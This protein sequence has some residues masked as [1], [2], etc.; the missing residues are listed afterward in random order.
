MQQ[1]KTDELDLLTVYKSFKKGLFNVLITIFNIFEFLKRNWLILTILLLIGLGLGFYKDTKDPQLKS[2][3]VLLKVNFKTVNYIYT[4][5]ETLN[6]KI[7]DNDTLF[8]KNVGFS[9]EPKIIQSIEITPLL[10]FND[11]VST[12]GSSNR[13][14]EALVKNLDINRDNINELFI[15]NL[16]EHMLK[17]DLIGDNELCEEEVYKIINYI[18]QNPLLNNLKNKNNE[19]LK[20]QISTYQEALLKTRKILDNYSK[21]TATVST[22][23]NMIVVDKNFSIDLILEKLKYIENELEKSENK[24]VYASQIAMPLNKIVVANAKMGILTKKIIQYPLILIFGFLILSYFRFL[25]KKI[26]KSNY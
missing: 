7:N 21:S 5:I 3:K 17:V 8:L 4:S 1:N 9:V 20:N 23:D 11:I 14:L 15:S 12:F 18:N 16:Q 19:L 22:K 24:L 26:K 2:S 13:T 25:Y 10:K 6:K